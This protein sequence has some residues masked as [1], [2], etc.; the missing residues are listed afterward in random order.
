MSKHHW[1]AFL[2]TLTLLLLF[3]SLNAQT[4]QAAPKSTAS[5]MSQPNTRGTWIWYP[6][7][8]E[9]WLHQKVSLRREERGVVMPPFW[10]LDT[11]YPSVSFVKNYQLTEDEE[12]TLRV[13]GKFNVKLDNKYLYDAGER[14]ILPAG[15]HKLTI[16][17]VNEAN[18]PAILVR[19]KSIVSDA[20]WLVSNGDEAI[21]VGNWNFADPASPPSMYKLATTEITTA[22]IE[23]SSSSLLIDFGKETFGFLKIYNLSGS[24]RATFYYGESRE[25]ALSPETCETLDHVS[26][27]GKNTEPYVHPKSRAMRYVNIVFDKSLKLGEV[28]LLYESL[29]V[30]YRGTFKSSDEKLNRIWETARYTLQLNAREFFLDGIKR[31]RWV[32]SGDAYQSFLMNYYLF[33]DEAINRRT[34]VALRGKDP[35][36]RHIN[37]ILDYSFY[38]FMGIYDYYL[39]TGD[40]AFIEQAY[41]QMSSLMEFCLKRRNSNGMVEGQKNDWVFI[42]WARMDKSGEVSFEQ[43]LFCRSLQTMALSAALLHKDEEAKMYQSLA[44][45]LKARIMSTFWDEKQGALIHG[46]RSGELNRDVTRYANMFALLLGYLDQ[47]KAA[48]VK[49]NVLMND[50]VQ[51]I[52]TPYM[53]FYELAALCEAGEEAYVMKEILNYWGGMLDAGATSFWEVYDPAEKGAARYAMYGR[54]FGKSLCH[55]WGASPIYLLGRYFLGVKPTKAGYEEYEI[56]PHLGELNWLEGTVPFPR[57]EV[58]V[59]LDRQTIRIKSTSGTGTLKFHSQVSPS[60]M[61]GEVKKTGNQTYEVRIEPGQEYVIEYKPL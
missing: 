60:V 18:L 10:R 3:V 19:G 27:N 57:G 31:D 53:R 2:A 6:G 39:Y 30:T 55:A 56:K 17:V 21:K 38:W 50:Q 20:S 59:Y 24:G 42:D 37:T 40:T 15:K 13:D 54:P 32:W 45:D 8:F 12:I 61:K 28:T 16:S 11:F 25:E 23:R 48:E 36:N 5:D 52:T 14:F 43:I 49:K 7:D 26:L 58:K 29:P 4:K 9:V 41:P 22:H 44:D 46:R 34:L 47:E 33:F 1:R 51:K 35:V